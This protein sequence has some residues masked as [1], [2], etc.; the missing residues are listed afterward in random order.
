MS[1]LSRIQSANAR[2]ALAV[3]TGDAAAEAEARRDQAYAKV[4]YAIERDLAG[5][6]LTPAQGARLIGMIRSRTRQG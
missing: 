1:S 5:R 4:A 6:E 3:R 2:I